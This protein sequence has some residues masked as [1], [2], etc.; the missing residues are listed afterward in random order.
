[1][2]FTRRSDSNAFV[3]V[4]LRYVVVF[5]VRA[6]TFL[7]D[8]ISGGPGF[9]LHFCVFGY[10]S[11][12]ANAT[13]VSLRSRLP[14][15]SFP[16]L[17]HTTQFPYTLA[18]VNSCSSRVVVARWPSPSCLTFSGQVYCCGCVVVVAFSPL[19]F[20]TIP[21]YTYFLTNVL[22]LLGCRI[23]YIPPLTT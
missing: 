13:R 18:R 22:L 9:L 19:G 20:S 23:V 5:R 17:V 3:A 4:C 6:F 8:S 1:M 7:A 21:S 11:Y 14:P 2:I 15:Q 10:Y 16:L 12:R